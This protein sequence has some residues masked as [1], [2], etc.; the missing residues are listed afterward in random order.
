MDVTGGK[1][2]SFLVTF[3]EY[4][5]GDAPAFIKNLCPDLFLKIQQQGQSQVTLLSPFNGLTYT[6]DDPTK[7]RQLSW[8]VYNN[9]GSGFVIDV[10]KDRYGS[11]LC[12]LGLKHQLTGF[13]FQLRRGKD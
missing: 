5:E 2:E 9:K 13:A 7:P 3:N 4:K 1:S 6:W 10:R 8:N 11:I 12:F